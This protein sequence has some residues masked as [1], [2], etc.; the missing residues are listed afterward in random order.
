MSASFLPLTRLS[1]PFTNSY[2]FGY[3]FI[4]NTK[5]LWYR[6]WKEIDA[7]AKFFSLSME[8]Y[9]ENELKIIVKVLIGLCAQLIIIAKALHFDIYQIP[10]LDLCTVYIVRIFNC[11]SLS[12]N[13]ELKQFS[14]EKHRTSSS[15]WFRPNWGFCVSF[16]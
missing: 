5:W 1:F 4:N 8:F 9:S 6:N 12:P 3:S 7:L 10:S 13:C 15:S 11:V 14:F 16:E 2:F